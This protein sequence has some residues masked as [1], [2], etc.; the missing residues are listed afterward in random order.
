MKNPIRFLAGPALALA[1]RSR[2]RRRP[3]ESAPDEEHAA[4]PGAALRQDPGRGL[5][6]RDRGGHEAAARRDRGDRRRPRRLRPSRTRSRRWSARASSSRART[7][8]S[9]TSSSPTRTTT[10]QKIKAELAP[11]LSAHHDAIYLNPKLFARVQ[12]IYD[13]ARR[14]RA[15]PGGEVPRRALPPRLRPRRAPTSATPTRRSSRAQRGVDARRRSSPTSSSPTRTPRPSSSDRKASSPASSEGDLAAAAEAA[16][17]KKLDGKWLLALQNTTQQPALASLRT[18]PCASASS[19]PRWRAATTAARTTRRP[20]SR[21]WRQLR[22][23]KAKLLGFATYADYVLDDQ[24]A[25]TPANAEKLMTDLVPPATAKARGEAAAIQKQIDA[26]K[27]GFQ[28][29]RGTGS[30]TPRRCARPSTTS[31]RRRSGRTSSS[32]ASCRTASSSPPT[33]CTASPSRSARTSRSTTR[34]SASARSSTPTAAR[35]RSTTA[36]SSCG[37]RRA[38]AR[39]A[40]ASST[41][42]GCS[43]RSRSSR[44]TP[45][46]RS[47]PPGEPALISFDDVTRLF[48]EFGHALHG[49]FQNVEYPTLGTDAARLRRVPVAVQRALG[50]RAD[51]VRQLREALQDR[52]A[53]AGGARRE[54]QEDQDVQPGLRHDRVPRRGPARHGLAL[55]ARRRD[56]AGRRRV[57]EGDARAAQG[58]TC[59]RCRRATARPTSRTSGTGA[60]RPATTPTSGPRSSTTTPTT[61]SRRTAA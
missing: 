16:K 52:R 8:S 28:A 45:T 47:R 19:R 48:H 38:A 54:D 12:A 17:E 7:R 11:K 37:P 58:R 43:A 21:A 61:G 55:A 22:A 41:R 2:P 32:T 42:A 23:E 25:K 34:T 27:G 31:T 10:L 57:R 1:V 18:A 33:R 35:S 36:T 20:S 26:E 44:T 13:A 30:S 50:L 51:G 5:P 46:S 6:A 24:M 60:T 40:T 53:D 4:L 56:A 49:M 29:H 39:G 14:A 3:R 9:S 15:R 59:P